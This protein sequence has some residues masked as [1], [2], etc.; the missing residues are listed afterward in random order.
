MTSYAQCHPKQPTNKP[1]WIIGYTTRKHLCIDLDNTSF[2]KVAKLVYMIMQNFSCVGCCLI[3]ESSTCQYSQKLFYHPLKPIETTTKRANYHIIF[4]NKIPYETSCKIIETLAVLGV[5]NK[6]Y[7]RIRQFR[8]DMT[9]RTTKAE[10]TTGT[11]PA[12]KISMLL[13]NIHTKKMGNG[14]ESFLKFYY[15]SNPQ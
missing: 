9:I 5:I 12:P 15:A 2:Y 6:E 7:V 13:P 11:K 1:D 8:N 14:I 4:D 3:M 10:Y